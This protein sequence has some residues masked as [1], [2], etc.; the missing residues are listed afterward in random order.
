MDYPILW[1]FYLRTWRSHPKNLTRE[2]VASK[3]MQI[4]INQN[5]Q[6]AGPFTEDKIRSMLAAKSVAPNDYGWHEGLTDWQPLNSF[7]GIPAQPST[8][9]PPPLP[10]P[11]RVSTQTSLPSAKQSGHGMKG[12]ILDFSI[13]R[14]EGV[15]SGD[16]NRRYTF[17]GDEWRLSESPARGMRV[18]FVQNGTSATA[19]FRELSKTTQGTADELNLSVLNPY[20]KDEFKKIHDS[21][22]TYKG[23]WNWAAFWFGPIWALT[24]GAWGAALT[25]FVVSLLTLGLGGLV[26]GFVFGIRGNYIYYTLHVKQKQLVG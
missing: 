16:D 7:L 15:I 26:Y 20:Y 12:S 14:N 19:V 25:S 23:K 17:L 3:N 5:G 11:A 8:P 1:I 2:G 18:D 24:K 10:S 22:E 9:V 4:F 6:Q 21:G 13:Q